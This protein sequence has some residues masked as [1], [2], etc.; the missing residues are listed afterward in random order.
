MEVAAGGCG[1]TNTTCTPPA[2]RGDSHRVRERRGE[3]DGDPEGGDRGRRPSRYTAEEFALASAARDA[4]PG[5]VASILG[6]DGRRE[7]GEIS[8]RGPPARIHQGDPR[9]EGA[10]REIAIKEEP[11]EAKLGEEEHARRLFE[12]RAAEVGITQVGVRLRCLALASTDGR[13]TILLMIIVSACLLAPQCDK[14]WPAEGSTRSC[15]G[16]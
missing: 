10:D 14:D 3:A 11:A 7:G 6:Y 1:S 13:E 15:A 16:W 4:A 9:E 2:R 8:P 5:E 12:A